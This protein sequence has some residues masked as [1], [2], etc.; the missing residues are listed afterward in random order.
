MR[1]KADCVTLLESSHADLISQPEQSCPSSG[2]RAIQVSFEQDT[3]TSALIRRCVQKSIAELNSKSTVSQL[4]DCND[5]YYERR[6][7]KLG[8][9]F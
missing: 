8:T 3:R 6:I 1:F 9:V 7:S 4:A 2:D 5:A